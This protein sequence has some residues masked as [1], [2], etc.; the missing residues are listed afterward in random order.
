MI[1]RILQFF[2]GS[3][4][5][6]LPWQTI[7]IY[8]NQYLNGAKWEYGTLG[9]YAIEGLLWI[10]I[11]F[12]LIW[13][14]KQAIPRMRNK[15]FSFT[16]DRLQIFFIFLFVFYCFLSIFWSLDKQVAWQQANRVMEMVVFAFVIFLGPLSFT[17]I[18]RW[19][20]AGTALQGVLALFQ[21][22]AQTTF[23][24]KWLGLSEHPAMLAGTSIVQGETGERVLRAYGAFPHPNVLGGYLAVGIV[25][26]FIVFYFLSVKNKRNTYYWHIVL[27]LQTAGLFVSFSRSAWLMFGLTLLYFIFVAFK[28]RKYTPLF[29]SFF[30]FLLF[31]IGNFPLLHTRVSQTAATEIRSTE[32]RVVGYQEALNMWKQHPLFG[33]G[34]GN[35]STASFAQNPTEPAWAYQPVHMVP[36]LALVELGGVGLGMVIFLAGFMLWKGY[37]SLF[38]IGFYFLPLP[39]AL[40][41]HYM[42]SLMPGLILA[43]FFLGGLGSFFHSF[44]T[45]LPSEEKGAKL[46]EKTLV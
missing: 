13:Y 8:K 42:F 46:D 25:F 1:K 17:Q 19:F 40:F 30:V 2:L 14:L 27:A 16:Q 37:K 6:L 44:S 38:I 45:F 33:V 24:F 9:F 34:I 26:T 7:W 43:G 21:F 11:V 35:Y 41:D 39:L 32:E 10:S 12:F 23:S 22:F 5:F 20:T 4:L 29:L 18:V 3:L 15:K 28:K 31:S 36:L